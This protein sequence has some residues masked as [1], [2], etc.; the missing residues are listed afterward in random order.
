M[1]IFATSA[2]QKKESSWRISALFAISL[3][4]IPL[5]AMTD[6][7]PPRHWRTIAQELAR[8]VDPVKA[9]SLL[10]ELNRAIRLVPYEE[11]GNIRPSKKP[12]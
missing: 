8:E 3:N 4:R 2:G 7:N 6:G 5:C 9:H 12:M 1:E 10:E 11:D